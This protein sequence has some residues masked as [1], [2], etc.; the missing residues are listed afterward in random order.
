MK[1][2]DKLKK[3]VTKGQSSHFL[4]PPKL[5]SGKCEF[6]KCVDGSALSWCNYVSSPSYLFVRY[7]TVTVQELA[8][9]FF[10]GIE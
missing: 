7:V 1:H 5:E 6:L 2:V 3:A 8:N 10:S 9:S 4:I